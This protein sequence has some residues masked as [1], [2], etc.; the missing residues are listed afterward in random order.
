MVQILCRAALAVFLNCV[1][2]HRRFVRAMKCKCPTQCRAVFAYAPN[3]A[4]YTAI[5][6]SAI[7]NLQVNSPIPILSPQGFASK[8]SLFAALSDANYSSCS[9]IV[10]SAIFD[11]A[12]GYQILISSADVSISTTQLTSDQCR[13]AWGRVDAGFLLNHCLN[14]KPVILM[15]TRALAHLPTKL[16]LTA[17]L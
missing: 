4:Q 16:L 8:D 5:A 9:N 10:L 1:T 12:G 15:Q 6:T 3:T 7:A 13:A 17:P 11:A 14:R 2:L